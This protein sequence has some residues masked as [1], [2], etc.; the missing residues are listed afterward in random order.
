M[1]LLIT[2]CLVE[3]VPASEN[4]PVAGEVLDLDCFMRKT[5]PATGKFSLA[6]ILSAIQ[7]AT[8][9]SSQVPGRKVSKIIRTS[10]R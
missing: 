5:S 9:Q 8:P 10:K 7:A 1:Y 4:L 6:G 2:H 3:R